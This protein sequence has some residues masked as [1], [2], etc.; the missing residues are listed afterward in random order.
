MTKF[1]KILIFGVAVV[2][3]LV[4]VEKRHYNKFRKFYRPDI[5]CQ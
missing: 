5:E 2:I 3:A 4:S 1:G